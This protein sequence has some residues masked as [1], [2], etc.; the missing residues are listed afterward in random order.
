MHDIGRFPRFDGHVEGIENKL[1][2]QVVRHGPADDAPRPGIEDDGE[3]QE[4]C[5]GRHVG[6]V[7]HPQQVR[8]R[9]REDPAD[10][11]VR[12][13]MRRLAPRRDREAPQRHTAQPDLAHQPRHALAG[14][15]RAL[16]LQLGVHARSAIGAVRARMDCPDSAQ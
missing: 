9:R 7:G 1:R 5:R 16:G 6:D 3:E 14:D 10:E 13:P 12:R 15:R 8:R 2:A 4:A 11:V